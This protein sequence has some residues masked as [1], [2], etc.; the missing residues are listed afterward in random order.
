MLQ[1]GK[2]TEGT[3]GSTATQDSSFQGMVLI[4]GGEFQMGSDE[5]D[6]S[7]V[8][9]GINLQGPAHSEKVESFYLDI[10]EVTNR[11][12]KEFVDA[13]GYPPPRHWT[14]NG[15]YERE[16]AE[17]PVTFVSWSDANNYA[18]WRGR[19]LPT[20]KEWEYAARSGDRNFKYPWGNEFRP[21]VANVLQG[22]KKTKPAAV[23]T[24]KEDRNR[25]GV[26]DL[27]GNVSEWVQDFF[28]L[29]NGKPSEFDNLKV[30]RGGHFTDPKETATATHR[31]ADAANTTDEN[32]LSVTGFRCARSLGQN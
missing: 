1:R 29:Y 20:E 14:N 7:N 27:G 30:Y 25:F 4:E 2:P 8:V 31:W 32:T 16:D 6:P 3:A 11:Q 19:R 15:S 28:K 21:G 10:N 22:V 13:R 26:N 9:N 12:Y 23:G 24:Y 18:T 17:L 5:G